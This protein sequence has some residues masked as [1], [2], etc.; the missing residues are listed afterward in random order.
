[1]AKKIKINDGSETYEIVDKSDNLICEMRI[2]PSD[3]GLIK[4][5]DEIINAINAFELKD[6]DELSS[7]VELDALL[8]EKMGDLLGKDVAEKLF[9]KTAPCSPLDNG[10][11]YIAEVLEGIIPVIESVT[12]KRAQQMQKRIEKYTA[13]YNK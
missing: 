13:A 12:N 1:M 10:N 5:A 7:I 6:D 2:N 4:K 3:T 9:E 11:L 8:V